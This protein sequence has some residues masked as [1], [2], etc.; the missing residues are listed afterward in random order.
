M[1]DTMH[2]MLWQGVMTDMI[3]VTMCEPGWGWQSNAVTL[4]WLVPLCG[5]GWSH[6]VTIVCWWPTPGL[7]PSRA[8]PHSPLSI[9]GSSG[10]GSVWPGTG[11]CSWYWLRDRS[12]CSDLWEADSQHSH[13]GHRAHPTG[14]GPRYQWHPVVQ[15]GFIFYV[16]WCGVKIFKQTWLWW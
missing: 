10:S 16:N 14:T 12:L 11:S 7:G 4:A 6:W 2:D 1:T 9:W 15:E 13:P 8:A 3:L 5:L